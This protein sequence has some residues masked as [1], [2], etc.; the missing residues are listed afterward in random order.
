MK[1]IVG[2]LLIM[3][4]IMPINAFAAEVN[5]SEKT[6]NVEVSKDFASLKNNN[7]VEGKYVCVDDT[8]DNLTVQS[9]DGQYEPL[10]TCSGSG[11]YARLNEKF[12]P[13]GAVSWE[14]N[15]RFSTVHTF[16]G[17][18]MVHKYVGRIPVLQ[19]SIPVSCVGAVGR[20]CG[21]D[22]VP[23]DLGKGSYSISLVGTARDA[24]QILSWI[25]PP[26][27]IGLQI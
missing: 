19:K 20:A 25:V 4:L 11:G 7:L 12:G 23:L 14:I 8:D 1:K 3:L 17:S 2:L 22:Y 18:I 27:E 9:V 10:S 21:D 5:G 24:S 26:C 16:T 13:G 6:P 15:P